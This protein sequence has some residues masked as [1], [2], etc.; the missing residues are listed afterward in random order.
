MGCSGPWLWP[1][2]LIGVM[3]S[4]LGLMGCGALSVLSIGLLHHAHVRLS[5][6]RVLARLR[7]YVWFDVL[8][9]LVDLS[10]FTCGTFH[11]F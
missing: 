3:W 7:R 2:C 1:P 5:P 4:A 10:T 6:A 11:K 8:L 9:M